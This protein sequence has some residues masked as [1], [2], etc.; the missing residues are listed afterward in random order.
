MA[1]RL[2]KDIAESYK[3]LIDNWAFKDLMRELNEKISNDQLDLDNSRAV[4]F[5]DAIY[6]EYRGFRKAKKWIDN[7]IEFILG[8]G[9]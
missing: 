2:K 5:N 3:I 6:F 1:D 7:H 8:E 4:E 9:G